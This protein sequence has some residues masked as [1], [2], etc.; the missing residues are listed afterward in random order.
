MAQSIHHIEGTTYD[1][2]VFYSFVQSTMFGY[3]R[4]QIKSNVRSPSIYSLKYVYIYFACS[5][6]L[7]HV[8][9]PTPCNLLILHLLLEGTHLMGLHHLLQVADVELRFNKFTT[10]FSPRN[11]LI[12]LITICLLLSKNGS[13][14]R[15]ISLGEGKSTA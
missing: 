13:L 6:S 10:K 8:L 11:A 5:C 9:V 2:H 15:S 7:A 12:Q 14:E 1:L 3:C 4:I